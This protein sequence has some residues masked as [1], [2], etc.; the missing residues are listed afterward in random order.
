MH[1][2]TPLIALTKSAIVQL[3]TSLG[4]DYG[5]THSCYDPDAAGRSCGACDSCLLRRKG[6]AEAGLTDPLVYP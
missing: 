1:I 6:F 3:G 5:L 4:V 2:H